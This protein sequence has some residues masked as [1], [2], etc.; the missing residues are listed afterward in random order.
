MDTRIW[1]AEVTALTLLHISDTHADIRRINR[2]ADWLYDRRIVVDIVLHSGDIGDLSDPRAAPDEQHVSA[3]GDLSDC[4]SA[5]ENISCRLF[6]IPGNH[7]PQS[8]FRSPA[9]QMST[10]SRNVHDAPLRIAP[11]LFLLAAGGSCDSPYLAPQSDPIGF[12]G[13]PYDGAKEAFYEASLG[14]QWSQLP[15]GVD[16]LVMT[17]PGPRGSRTTIWNDSIEMGSP[18]VA[19]FLGSHATAHEQ[20]TDEGRRILANLHGHTHPGFGCGSLPGCGCPVSNAGSAHEGRF[21]LLHLSRP[22]ASARWAVADIQHLH[23]D[24]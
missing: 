7:D 21:S 5:L 12:V 13:Y 24:S 17:H 23:V 1:P 2:I 10:H 22:S 14:R 18:G 16:V 19:A 8:T 15:P 20:A 4:L 6:Y 3:E 9:P 11:D